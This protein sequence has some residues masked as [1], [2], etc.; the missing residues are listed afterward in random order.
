VPDPRILKILLVEDD[1]E[2][3]QLLSEA[4]VEIEENR[5][6]CN[7]RTASVVQ[8]GQLA[9]A[10]D[11]L[12]QGC[13]NNDA[14]DIVLL[15]LSLPD[16]PTLLYS[17]LDTHA[18]ARGTPIVVL[19]DQADENLAHRLLREGAQDV[20]VKP[21]LECAPLA[22]SIRYAVERHRRARGLQASAFIDNLTG[23]LS[24]DA[25]LHVAA[26]YSKLPLRL[27]AAS[28]EVLCDDRD[29]REPRLI[30][31]AET[32]RDAFEPP[33]FLGRWDRS[34]FCAITAGLAETTV[35]AM[36]DRAAAKIGGDVRFLLAPLHAGDNLEDLLAAELHPREKTA[37]LAD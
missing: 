9:G 16:S 30:L 21:E 24:S 37:I 27:L 2:D 11:C 32:L 3:E 26:G 7:W 17:F 4:F 33:S 36:L 35:E 10:V 22:R 18:K 28:V 5:Q 20:L 14:F 6:W 1:L 31:A 34:R 25:L 8:V 13:S 19:A 29:S 23:V 12:G 15:N